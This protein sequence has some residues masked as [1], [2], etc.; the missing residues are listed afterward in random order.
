MR[1]V[2]LCLTLIAGCTAAACG[3]VGG[4]GAGRGGRVDAVFAAYDRAATPGCA[5]AVVENQRSSYARGYGVANLEYDLPLTADSVFRVGS[6]SKQFT[7]ALA[8][9][10]EA[11]GVWSLQDDVGAWL[12]GLPDFGE[13]V[14]LADLVH[15]TSGWRDY[16]ELMALAGV[17]DLDYY[18]DADLMAFLRRQRR[19]NFAPGTRYRYSNTGYFLLGAAIGRA[20]GGSLR[21]IAHE[22][23]FGPLG[24]AASHFHDDPAHVVARRAT[25]YEPA[26]EGGYRIATTTLPIVGDGGVFTSAADMARW[27][28]AFWADRLGIAAASVQR[29]TLRDGSTI[30]YAAGIEHGRYRGAEILEHGGSFVGYRA[31]VLRFPAH[32]LSVVVLCNRSD[33]RPGRLARRVADVW[34]EGAL[35]PEEADVEP[36]D[37]ERWVPAPDEEYPLALADL[38]EYE[39][40]YASAELRVTYELALREGR[41][42]WLLE[43]RIDEPLYGL[44]ADLFVAG[45]P[46]RLRFV[47][48]REGGVSG[49]L[50][51]TDRVADLWFERIE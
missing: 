25:G 15:H 35:G 45:W 9:L 1:R 10:L 33:A 18:D 16:L 48:A 30:E 28:A 2:P 26:A 29:G 8:L 13:T 14:T 32:R 5:L 3:V 24:M 37:E 21:Q 23:I 12:P 20:A 43:R 44:A 11:D 36:A 22:R 40:R 49:L 46:A 19:L 47:R 6:V 17:R 34:L 7:A 27:E 31:H 41:L 51:D 42:H 38:R 4:R 39:G 50:L